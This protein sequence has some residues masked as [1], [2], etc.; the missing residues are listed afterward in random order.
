MS[1]AFRFSLLVLAVLSP[2]LAFGAAPAPATAPAAAYHLDMSEPVQ[3]GIDVLEAEGFAPLRGKRFAL[4]T[5]PAGVD[6]RGVSTIDILRHA[7][8]LRLVA[9]FGTEHGVYGGPAA[10]NYQDKLDPRTGLMV[11]SLYNGNMQL[12]HQPS[13]AQLKGIDA[14]V[15]DLQDIGSRSYTFTGAMKQAME[16]CF[17]HH[18][19]VIILDRPNPLGGLKVDGPMLDPQWVGPNLVNA[20]NVPYVHGMTIGEL[21]RMAKYQPGILKIPEAARLQGKLTVIPMQGWRRSMRWPETGLTWVPTSPY[22]PD[23]AAIAGYPL[24][25]LGTFPGIANFSHGVGKHP[26][27]SPQ[28]PFRGISHKYVKPEVLEKE[29]NALHLPGVRFRRISV[30]N[31]KVG[32]PP[33]T[34]LFIEITDWDE[35]HPTDLNFYLMQ[36]DCRYSPHNP[37]AAVHAGDAG[38]FLRQMGSTAFFNDLVVHGARVDVASYLRAWD[39]KAAAFQQRS[40]QFWL[41]Q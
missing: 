24:T 31:M 32:Q 7:P 35:W 10:T 41:Y 2:A 19:E 21:A 12:V 16:G 26:D 25:G 5:H 3:L 39:A 30:P 38:G 6:H 33:A 13:A 37:Y 14:L 29:L 34:G 28:Y 17:L 1:G 15:I 11:F 18:V 23:F 4:L 22:V 36:L 20:F 9:L 8:G 27:G 40:R